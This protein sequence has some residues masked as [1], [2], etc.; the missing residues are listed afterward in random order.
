MLDR[1][2]QINYIYSITLSYTGSCI[3]TKRN[4]ATDKFIV[5]KWVLWFKVCIIPIQ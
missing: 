3:S 5:I 1:N 4:I 2:R